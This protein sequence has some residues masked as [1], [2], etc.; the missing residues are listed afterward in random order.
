MAA[1]VKMKLTLEDEGRVQLSH[2]A[3]DYKKQMES[4]SDATD[5]AAA[6]IR[7]GFADIQKQL[8][9]SK[10][11]AAARKS[12]DPV[13][14]GWRDSMGR[15]RTETG[16]FM[17]EMQARSHAFSLSMSKISTGIKNMFTGAAA[18]L[19]RLSPMIMGVVGIAGT[20][21]FAM[22]SR[23]IVMAR[24][25]LEKY[26][27]EFEV[28]FKS[29]EKATAAMD[30]VVEFAAKTPFQLPEV[31]Q[32]TRILETLTRGALSSEEGLRMVGDAASGV[33]IPINQLAMWFGRLYDGIKSGRPVGEATMRMQE[34]GIM[35]G[36]VRNQLEKMQKQG[37]AGA[38][39]WKTVSKSFERYA[40]MM[41]QKS[42]TLEG[43]LSNIQD[44]WWRMKTVIADKTF[45]EIK[46]VAEDVMKTMDSMITNGTAEKIG[47]AF[48]RMFSVVKA[49]IT[50]I[51]N[52]WD[53]IKDL[54]AIGAIIGASVM[55]VSLLTNPLTQVML[56]TT[57]IIAAWKAFG[58]PGGVVSG[59][60][61]LFQNVA[62][63]VQRVYYDL[64]YIW[65]MLTR[66]KNIA[67]GGQTVTQLQEAI[68]EK[69]QKMA[70]TTDEATL[71]GYKIQLAAMKRQLAERV[72]AGEDIVPMNAQEVTTQ[73]EANLKRLKESV[74]GKET[75]EW[76]KLFED[77][78]VKSAR[79]FAQMEADAELAAQAVGNIG[80]N[81]LTTEQQ[82]KKMMGVFSEKEKKPV[83]AVVGQMRNALLPVTAG[84]DTDEMNLMLTQSDKLSGI[85]K[86]VGISMI[87][88]LPEF[89]SKYTPA[90]KMAIVNSVKTAA[91]EAI[92]P[93]TSLG[94]R[95]L[96]KGFILGMEEVF[97]NNYSIQGLANNL[98]RDLAAAFHE[99]FSA[100]LV[101]LM[102]GGGEVRE[103]LADFTGEMA[104]LM[105]RFVADSL[106]T[107]VDGL[108]K[109]L[110][111][112]MGTGGAGIIAGAMQTVTSLLDGGSNMGSGIGSGLGMILGTL[113]PGA[114][115]VGTLL[116]GLAGGLLGGLFD[117]DEKVREDI[118]KTEENT[119]QI[120]AQMEVVNRNLIGLRQQ[121]EPYPL[122][123][124]A[125]FS[126]RRTEEQLALEVAMGG[127]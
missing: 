21:G 56:L 86:S 122:P 76:D 94:S 87:S 45:P 41:E 71:S 49:G 65:E 14:G 43:V 42:H 84:I 12:W 124:S 58:L 47:D 5:K 20:G 72:S 39:I 127:A 106:T 74:F 61:A 75:S 99:G 35:S 111:E 8:D 23:S 77:I 125:Y 63:F 69:A 101:A 112:K 83:T 119:A 80:K 15:L 52:N 89:A 121:M 11:S 32:A 118:A 97:A 82:L 66:L 114:G 28:L 95:M 54:L 44:S 51:K 31:I 59:L 109:K 3:K 93:T 17:S 24:A 123:S 53:T 19:R 117:K 79:T 126:S 110:A 68:K 46:R 85:S 120:A 90:L 25:E 57:G 50:F 62:M 108:M 116:G 38:E 113:I 91:E 36:D 6:D 26:T 16:Q 34:L 104:M 7:R 64:K 1:Q 88:G 40:G 22:M 98:G 67:T 100:S 27:T 37:V 13:F 96:N 70:S 4:M 29:K 48:Y 33:G 2:V 18:E 55:T 102:E 73:A 10:S 9:A 107:Q 78:D 92:D 30:M 60:A 105:K 81:A 115:E 103:A